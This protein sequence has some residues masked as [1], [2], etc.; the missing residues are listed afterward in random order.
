[1]KVFVCQDH[2][3][4][5]LCPFQCPVLCRTCTLPNDKARVLATACISETE[6][7][8]SGAN[9]SASLLSHSLLWR[10]GQSSCQKW[11]GGNSTPWVGVR[12]GRI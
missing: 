4:I 8:G 11:I 2:V 6:I 5:S 9:V 10:E 12:E 1:M 7:L 3:F